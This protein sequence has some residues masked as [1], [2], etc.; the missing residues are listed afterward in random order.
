[1][2]IRWCTHADLHFLAPQPDTISHHETVDSTV[3]MVLIQ[4][5]GQAELGW[6]AGYIPRWLLVNPPA[7]DQ[8]SKH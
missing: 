3:C 6:M 4:R 1:M 2:L 8:P 7:G 5:D